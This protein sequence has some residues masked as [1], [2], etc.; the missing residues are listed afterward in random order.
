MKQLKCLEDFQNLNI[1]EKIHLI[2]N[3]EIHHYIFWGMHLRDDMKEKYFLALESSDYTT[4]KIFRVSESVAQILAWYVGYDSITAGD[5]MIE[6]LRTRI[7]A[8]QNIYQKN[9]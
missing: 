3:G 2:K 8:I 7:R 5:K 9:K 1:G 6:Q 4:V